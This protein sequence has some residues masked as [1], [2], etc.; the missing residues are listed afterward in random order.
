M[1][2]DALLLARTLNCPVWTAD[3]EIAQTPDQ[4][5]DCAEKI[6]KSGVLYKM[7]KGFVR[8]LEREP[9]P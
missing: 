9:L 4:M 2:G 6:K 8:A 3:G 5:A 7:K 1:T